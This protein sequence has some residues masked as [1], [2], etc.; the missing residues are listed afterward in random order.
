MSEDVT[1]S[2]HG[3][4]PDNSVQLGSDNQL[5]AHFY[6][7]A[8]VNEAR[9]RAEGSPIYEAK[10]FIKIFHPGEKDVIDRPVKE[11]DKYRFA[12]RWASYKQNEKQAADGTPLEHLFPGNPEIVAQLRASHCET[13]QQ[14]AA[15]TDSAATSIPFGGKLKEK[16]QTFLD[17]AEKA[18]GY[19]ALEK[20]LEEKSARIRELEDR[21]TAI[22]TSLSDED[23]D[24]PR[25]PGWP[26]GKKRKPQEMTDGTER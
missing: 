12:N 7:R 11:M 23:E 24:P 22:E 18:K 6:K 2:V 9:S 3:L 14:L 1:F 8:I 10:D 16:A 26:L 19:H 20:Q 5:V 21:L 15:M 4:N 17:G 13:I 25:K